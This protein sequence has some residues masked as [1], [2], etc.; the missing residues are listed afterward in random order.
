MLKLE[1]AILETQTQHEADPVSGRRESRQPHAAPSG[2]VTSYEE[3]RGHTGRDVYF[4]PDRYQRSELG[5]IGVAVELD[6]GDQLH[7]CELI[8]VS[9]NGVAFVW[10]LG[11]A[12]EVGTI[13]AEI[14]VKF[15]EYE[16]YRGEARI[17][18]VRRDGL[19][20]IA[21]ASLVDTLMNIEDVL[22]LRDVKSLAGGG[23]AKG[24]GLKDAAW[25]VNG[26]HRFKALVSELRLLLEDAQRELGQLEGLLPWH[27]VHGD[28][29]S[30]ARDALIE[31]VKN[32]VSTDI[33]ALSDEIDAALRLASRSERD[34]L[35]AFSMR[36]V[37]DLLM[38]SPWMNRARQ[39]PLG[40]PGDYELMTRV[41]DNHFAGASLFAK[42]VDLSFCLTPAAVAVRARKDMIKSRLARLINERK[43]KPVRILSIAAGPAQ[44]VFELLEERDSM[45]GPLE[46]VLFDQDKRALSFSYGRLQR[47]VQSRFRDQVTVTHLHDSIRHLLRGTTVFS[48]AGTFDAVYSC[49]LVD[50]LQLPTAVSL[51]RSLYELLSPGGTLYVG[52]MVPSNPCRWFME[53]HLE[54][55]LVY[56][57]REQMLDFARMAAPGAAIELIEEQ[58]RV[59][60]FVSF[61]RE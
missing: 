56:R 50:Y 29:D 28:Q 26:Q 47:L 9:Q 41:Y 18:S 61:T 36:S 45:S 13:L 34:A 5:P 53:L 20:T 48:G 46:I 49:G 55:Y 40:Y 14:V 57:E 33:V 52:N 8:D 39:K 3:L 24:L 15:D 43:G 16:A 6:L 2:E 23:D 4:R 11:A 30:P 25:R 12:V 35:Q 42:A 59:N 54:W 32:E 17:S 44:E 58:T 51:C 37:H 10:P 7:R 1:T 27:V 38:H 21:G 19:R 22:Q 60:P 31:R